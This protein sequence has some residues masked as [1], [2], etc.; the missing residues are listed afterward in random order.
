MATSV[1]YT[2]RTVDL[3]GFQNTAPSG[4]TEVSLA[5]FGDDGRSHV[6]TGIQKVAQRFVLGLLTEKGSQFHDPSYGTYFLR[7]LKLGGSNNNARFQLVF[8]NASVDILSQQNV[9]LTGDE[10]DDEVLASVVLQSFSFPTPD[11]LMMTVKLLSR[12]GESRVV[13]LPVTLAIR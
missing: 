8:N 4:Q 1:D 9:R 7:E 10:P 2:G 6:T 11:K 13:R 3:L 12:A 5:L